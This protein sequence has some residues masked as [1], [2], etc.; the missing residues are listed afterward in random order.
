MYLYRCFKCTKYDSKNVIN[1]LKY[2]HGLRDHS[3]Q[4]KC[5]VIGK[6]C[7]SV[8]LTFKGLQNHIKNGQ[9]AIEDNLENHLVKTASEP[10]INENQ[11]N[12]S[13]FSDF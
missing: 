5:V 7:D 1:H 11:D 13:K 3:E 6:K 4:L 10:E 8:Y 2:Y 9:P 12:V